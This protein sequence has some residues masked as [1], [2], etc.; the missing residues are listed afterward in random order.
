MGTVLRPPLLRRYAAE[1]GL[2]DVEILPIES[3]FWRFY[4]LLS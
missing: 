1:A 4:R 2:R 3:D